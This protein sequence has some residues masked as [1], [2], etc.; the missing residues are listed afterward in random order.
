MLKCNKLE[1]LYLRRL[2]YNQIE[3]LDRR[4]NKFKRNRPNHPDVFDYDHEV[5]LVQS[6]LNSMH[7]LLEMIDEA[8][9]VMY[10]DELLTFRE[11]GL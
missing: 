7:S 2:V 4:M 9:A 11:A 1:L 5:C 3:Y 10:M 6:E 8:Y